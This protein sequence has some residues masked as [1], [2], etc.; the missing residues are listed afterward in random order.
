M[1]DGKQSNYF[2][3]TLL[4]ARDWQH[5]PQFDEVC[6]WWKSRGRG[7]CALVGMGG[8]GKTAIAERFLNV[9]VQ[10]LGC[11]DPEKQAEAW[12][13]TRSLPS[14]R[15][16]FVYSFYDDDKPENFFHHLQIWLEGTSSPNK[17][18]SPTQLMFDIQQHQGLIVLDGLERVQESGARGGFGRLTSP[19]LRDLLN[20]IA[21]GS[22]R[23]LSVL[24]T[25]RFPLTD[26][27]DSQ[28]R[29][30][31]T[32]AVDQI[33]LAAG[34][35]LLRER[36]VRGTNMQLAPIVEHCGRHALTVDLAGGYIKEYGHGDPTTP[37]NLGTVEEL[38]AEA[39]QEP[40]DD[41]RDVL[42]QSKR[43]AR[44]AQRYREAM[45]DSD[46]A[47][48][49]L[50][51]RICLFRLGVDCETLATIFCGPGAYK[52]AIS[53]ASLSFL[54]LG[55]VR[56]RLTLLEKIHLV[57]SSTFNRFWPSSSRRTYTVHPVIRDGFLEGLGE[58]S[59]IVLHRA[60]SL[61]LVELF[62]RHHTIIGNPVDHVPNATRG[63]SGSLAIYSITLI[64][65][66]ND[67]IIP[68]DDLYEEIIFH[69][70]RSGYSDN[71]FDMYLATLAKYPSPGRYERNLRICES[72]SSQSQLLTAHRDLRLFTEYGVCLR[73][74][75]QL[76]RALHQFEMC[77]HRATDRGEF[78]EAT[79][80]ASFM[81][82]AWLASGHIKESLA[83]A[84]NSL[85][86]AT[87]A[88]HIGA[89]CDSL[90]DRAT[91]SEFAGNTAD[92][93]DGFLAAVKLC[94]EN[95]P[96][97]PF[98]RHRGIRY[99]HLLLGFGRVEEARRR[100]EARKKDLETNSAVDPNEMPFCLLVLT[101]ALRAAGELSYAD[102]VYKSARD[103]ALEQNAIEVFC[104]C[105]LVQ[106][107][108]NLTGTISTEEASERSSSNA[109]TVYSERLHAADVSLGKGLKIARDCGYGLYHIDLLLER[110]RLHLLRGDAGAA[111]DDIEVALDT[112]IP[113]NEE[114]GQVE[115]LAANHEEC[116]YAWAIPVGLQLRAEALLLQ[117]AQELDRIGWTVPTN[118]TLAP[119]DVTVVGRVHP[120]IGQLIT[121]AKQLLHEALDRWH[122]L[123]DPEPTE[124]N[125]FVHPETGKEYNYKAEGTYK[126]L[127]DLDAGI[128]TRYPLELFKD[129]T[130]QPSVEEELPMTATPSPR[131]FISYTHDS[132]GHANNVL[133]LANRLRNDGIEAHI[134]QYVQNP[135][136]GWP[137][138][139]DNEIE[140]ADFVLVVFTERYAAKAKEAKRSGGR[141]ESVLILQD[142]YEGGMSNN[143]FIPVVLCGSDT[144]FILKWLKSVNRYLVDSDQ[145][146]ESLRRRLLN[147]P[148]I[149]PP[150]VGTP[151]KKGPTNP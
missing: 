91:A 84:D 93:Y 146:Y 145:G 46:E 144:S 133:Q 100:T 29:F 6:N 9:G 85:R 126:V 117:A 33:D 4:R 131:V 39:E 58:E 98:I 102:S 8:A 41:K 71:A 135:S 106:A 55:Q 119:T 38:Q 65:V 18:K 22:A 37:L 103:W 15:S 42:I 139:M 59:R 147:D 104:L 13:P 80:A 79:I 150:P 51:E 27:R 74:L 127:V 123:R 76:R 44:I 17:Q 116:G 48:L 124:D 113:A 62:N 90:C 96:T 111:L 49:A 108:R 66:P 143:K 16:V 109:S 69:K 64:H 97:H 30:F 114:T 101:E 148:A 1:A 110:A 95:Q 128:L 129:K 132:E 10:P 137:L 92:A 60:V 134:D 12:T 73:N 5:R 83:A 68:A 25:S 57:K 87:A 47:A 78:V 21:S 40:D 26:L 31:H 3:H 72:L 86:L 149:V 120:A 141:F 82:A 63:A 122:D 2:V 81:S 19:S 77:Q 112:G 7:V 70:V 32:I 67:K 105:E 43:F 107:R 151:V 11:Q 99:A 88:T 89:Q 28:P 35:S 121:D 125:N 14:P 115:L 24:V 136:E 53:G 50:L 118:A 20:H 52:V 130:D 34:V 54:D 23:E 140:V 138:W 75:G 61:S 45:L 56:Q 36:G 142:L 94:R